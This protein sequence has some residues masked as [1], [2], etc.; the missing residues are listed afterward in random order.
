MKMQ[1]RVEAG[2]EL[3][4]LLGICHKEMQRS[5]KFLVGLEIVDHPLENTLVTI[6][7]ILETLAVL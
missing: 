2:V 7:V 4:F 3:T 1:V 6:T 5:H